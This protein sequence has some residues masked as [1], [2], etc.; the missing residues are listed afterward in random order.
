MFLIRTLF[1]LSSVE[2]ASVRCCKS[3]F[4][5]INLHDKD[6]LS[7]P[8]HLILMSLLVVHYPLVC[9]AVQVVAAVAAAAALPLLTT[10]CQCFQQTEEPAPTASGVWLVAQILPERHHWTQ[11][12]KS[13]R[14]SSH[15]LNRSLEKREECV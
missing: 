9:S 6:L 10:G 15:S 12:S 4:T 2:R 3:L 14:E 11:S 1:K 8:A 5:Q 13:P 7:V